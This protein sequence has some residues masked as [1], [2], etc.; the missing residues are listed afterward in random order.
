MQPKDAIE[1]AK[2]IV[3]EMFGD[4][5]MNVALEEIEQDDAAQ[6]WKVTIGFDR[7]RTD[8]ERLRAA[9]Q[10]VTAVEPRFKIFRREYKVVSLRDVDAS[11][12]SIKNHDT[13]Q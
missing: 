8:L 11:L 10:T 9:T 2:R 7:V 4:D 1:T 5:A 13:V 3:H 12:V 6:I